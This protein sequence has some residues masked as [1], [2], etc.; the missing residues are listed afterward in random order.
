MHTNGVGVGGIRYI[1]SKPEIFGQGA[2]VR[3][4]KFG[5]EYHP[6]VFP[7]VCVWTHIQGPCL[8]GCEMGG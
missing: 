4:T 7:C 3:Q 6:P 8:P 2:G 1:A 5:N